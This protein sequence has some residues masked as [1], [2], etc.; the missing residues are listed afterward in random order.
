M[1][2]QKNIDQLN[3]L[4]EGLDRAKTVVMADYSGIGVNDIN[5]LRKTIVETGGELRVAKNTLLKLALEGIEYL[6][7]G[8]EGQISNISFVGPTVVLFS[9]EDEIGALKALYDFIKEHDLPKIKFGFM[10]GELIEKEKILQLAKLPGMDVL[11]GQLVG[12]MQSPIR[13]LV[14]TL[15][16][17]MQ[18]FVGV[19]EEIKRNKK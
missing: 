7:T 10:G 6:P 3:E 19:V 2:S 8:K 18:E 14:Y 4:K 9:Y 17:K 12:V 1:P 16:G 11:Q 13:E 15:H 5:R